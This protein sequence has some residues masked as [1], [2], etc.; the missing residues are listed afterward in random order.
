MPD[1]NVDAAAAL[2]AAGEAPSPGRGRRAGTR[3]ILGAE[4]VALLTLIKAILPLGANDWVQIQTTHNEQLE[5]YCQLVGPSKCGH[6]EAEVYAAGAHYKTNW[7][8][9]TTIQRHLGSSDLQ[10]D[11]AEGSH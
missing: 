3:N 2:A 7:T 8:L 11:S 9:N 10:Y 6:F 4:L 5:P 1:A